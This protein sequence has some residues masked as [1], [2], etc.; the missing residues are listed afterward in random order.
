MV[1]Y[2]KANRYLF[3]YIFSLVLTLG[4]LVAWIILLNVNSG[5]KIGDIVLLSILFAILFGGEL[6]FIILF[7]IRPRIILAFDD[8][9]V[10]V[11]LSKKRKVIF[12]FS[13][14]SSF[15]LIRRNLVLVTKSS[16]LHVVRFLSN[17]KQSE[18]ALKEGLNTFI[19]NHPDRYFT[20]DLLKDE[21][22]L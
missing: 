5:T 3:L 9:N 2:Q 12:P 8:E 11:Y 14:L 19:T 10:E 17:S 7:L 4:A 20:K 16:D 1:T 15:G 13:N 18:L 22:K 21:E 6:L